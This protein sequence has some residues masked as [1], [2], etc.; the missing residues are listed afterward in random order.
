MNE[1]MLYYAAGLFTI[2]ACVAGFV[3]Y[4][5]ALR[6]ID[7]WHQRRADKK[8]DATF[9]RVGCPGGG[10]RYQRRTKL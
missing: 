3:L 9:E 1:P 2:P 10:Y 8:F 4:V 5:A 6:K 7:A